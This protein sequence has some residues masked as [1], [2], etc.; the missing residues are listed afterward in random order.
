MNDIEKSMLAQKR[1]RL[2]VSGMEE[3]DQDCSY[4]L[5]TA[6]PMTL[7]TCHDHVRRTDCSVNNLKMTALE[8]RPE[9]TEES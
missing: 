6:G 1:V 5:A 9:R 2:C 7:C 3:L 8:S 4:T